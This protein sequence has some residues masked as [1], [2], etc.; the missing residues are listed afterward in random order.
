[1][2]T[3]EHEHAAG[4][5]YMTASNS[6]DD[7][8]MEKLAPLT[9]ADTIKT[10]PKEILEKLYLDTPSAVKGDLRKT[11]ANPTPAGVACLIICA[12]L[13]SIGSSSS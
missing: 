4:E 10:L 3:H 5:A 7:R 1:M 13:M 9:K 6:S 11:F 8:I 2:A 12:F